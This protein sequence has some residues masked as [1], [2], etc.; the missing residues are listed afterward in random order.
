MKC[1][2]ILLVCFGLFVW[3]CKS[4]KSNDNQKDITVEQT[5][6]PSES[7][8]L[9]RGIQYAY[10][11]NKFADE[12]Q[13]KFN[14]QLKIA[15]TSYY[16]GYVILKTNASSIRLL[17]SKIDTVLTADSLDSKFHNTMFWIAETY[18]MPFWLKAEYFEKQ[19]ETGNFV[20]SNYKS[21]LS[22]SVFKIST[23]P[24]TN[25]IDKIEYNTD[26]EIPVF[27]QGRLYFDKYITVN[28]IPV[29]MHWRIEADNNVIAKAKISRISYPDTF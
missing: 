16:D 19:R 5:V 23:H 26:I 13:V 24:L 3:G 10:N 21:P 6:L 14:I 15:D 8:S 4:D 18:A 29:A 12:T 27:N 17:N 20:V 1:N 25:I 28:R 11:T 2:F 7:S 22:K 9:L